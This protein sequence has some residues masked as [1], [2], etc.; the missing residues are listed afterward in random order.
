MSNRSAIRDQAYQFFQQEA[1]E[2]LHVLETGLMTFRAE[3]DV[4]FDVAK[5]HNLMRVAHSIKGGAASVNLPGIQRIAHKLED[6]F[7]ALYRRADPIDAT[8]EEA[9]LQAYDCLRRPLQEQ[10]ATGS[11]DEVAAWSQAE[12]VFAVLEEIFGDDLGAAIELPTAAEL[13]VDIFSEIFSNDI[14]EGLERLE[15]ALRQP[16]VQPISGEF[17]ATLEVFVGIG[18][19]LSLPGF[20][21]IAQNTLDAVNVHPDAV[22]QIGPIA[23]ENL[24][25]AQQEVLMGDYSQGGSPTPEFLA[26]VADLMAGR[27]TTALSF[28]LSLGLESDSSLDLDLEQFAG[29]QDTEDV[30]LDDIFGQQ[31]SFASDDRAGLDDIFGQDF[32]QDLGQDFA[33]ELILAYGQDLAQ[34]L[35]PDIGQGLSLDDIFGQLPGF[36]RRDRGEPVNL[37]PVQPPQSSTVPTLEDL[38]E[39]PQTSVEPTLDALSD[40]L[41]GPDPTLNL[42]PNQPLTPNQQVRQ[43][44]HQESTLPL[45][46]SAPQNSTPQNP[47]PPSPAPQNPAP[48]IEIA[49]YLTESVRVDFSRLERIN[50]LVGEL[51]TQEN[52]ALLQSQQ[53]QGKLKA[54]Q[55]RFNHFEQL[56]KSLQEW[57]DKS[58]RSE[59][60][61]SRLNSLGQSI[62]GQ[63]IAGQNIAEQNTAEPRP[64]SPSPDSQVYPQP[65]ADANFDALQMDTYSDLYAVM[66][67]SWEEILQMGETMRDMTVITQQIQNTQRQKKQTL[68]QVRTDLLWARMMPL[69][70]ALL[71]FP[72]M[73]RDLATQHSKPVRLVQ[74]GAAT[75]VD[76]GTL[77]KLYDPLVHLV[78]NA[79]AHGIESPEQRLQQGKPAEGTITIRAYHRGNQT[80]VEVRDDG[81]GIDIEKIR[82]AVIAHSLLSASDAAVATP[83]E[84]YPYL[85]APSLSTAAVVSDLAGRGM[86]LSAVQ[87]QVKEL[88]GTITVTSEPGQGTKFVLRFPLT[89]TI[90]KLLIFSVDSYAMA[91]PIDTLLAIVTAPEADIQTLQGQQFYRYEGEL[92]PLYPSSSFAQHYPLP[93]GL[94]EPSQ[95]MALPKDGKTPL[96]LIADGDRLMALEV[97]HILTEQELVI[98]PF[99]PVLTP[100]DYLYGCTILGD[101]S[102]VPVID[103]SVLVARWQHPH[104]TMDQLSFGQEDQVANPARITNPAAAGGVEIPTILVVDDS[105]TTRQNLTITLQKTGYHVIQAEDGREAL[106][107]LR[108]VPYIRAVFCDVEMPNMN[109]FEF[110]SHCRKHYPAAVLP[111]I[112]LT[113]RSSEKHRRI[114]QLLGVT[115]YLTKPYLEPVLLETLQDC[116]QETQDCLQ[117]TRS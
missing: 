74:I 24:R 51:V 67:A 37:D 91:I 29:A 44:R 42:A 59:V 89:L 86:G 109:G 2:L 49:P 3:L 52:S 15:Q 1:L 17:R 7:R 77:A 34:D 111:V 28:D 96:L 54:L 23:V 53:L 25:L 60:R 64:I 6:V 11:Y 55:H 5:V 39:F 82:A 16:Q 108:Q 100:P 68:K 106:A 104:Q 81:A 27:E 98:K 62:A 78:R 10:I 58:Q 33:Q 93:R 57:M 80:F 21:A 31:D 30:Q 35:T 36:E 76:K 102:L 73:L 114:A 90:A 65:L 63:S 18:E 38:F 19:L 26:Q 105:L 9:L 72:R 101:G 32:G 103:G 84:L 75:L 113:S 69:S 46:I 116:L 48:Q 92:V 97:D 83:E 115:H 88:K 79:F 112:F 85:F 45:Q 40:L 66:Q 71:R 107:K 56:T 4:A 47:V 61:G 50:N 13:G 12:P 22:L 117:K 20:T 94:G 99:S 41:V 43:S 110:L 87:A 70:D 8:I 95:A 14:E